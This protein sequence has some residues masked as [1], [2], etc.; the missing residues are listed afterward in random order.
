MRDSPER[1]F[2][3]ELS[4]LEFDRRVLDLAR[5]AGRPILERA[6]FL[7]IF[8]RNLDEF[9]QVRV[10]E[11]QD[12]V[13]ERD[14][15]PAPDGLT[16][17]AQLAAIR[18]RVL[19]LSRAAHETFERELRPALRTAGIDL[20]HWKELSDAERASTL[21]PFDEQ[22][23]PVLIPLGV[24]LTHPFP[25]VSGLS[26][27][28][29]AFV[30]A[31]AG[32]PRRLARVKVPAF[33]P[34]WWEVAPGR[35]TPVEEVIRAHFG[36]L[37]PEDEVAGASF[38]RVTRDAD[39]DLDEER[40]TGDLFKAVEAGLYRRRRASDA[41]RLEVAADLDPRIRDLL[42]LELRLERDEMYEVPG[43]LDLGALFELYERSPSE[44]KDAP[45]T[46]A[47]VFRGG[48]G[49]KGRASDAVF[50]TL[51][52]RDVLVHHPYESFESSVG[53]FLTAA[54]E[55]PAVRV[56]MTTLYRAGGSE[57]SIIQALQG[58]AARGK[59]IVALVELK[60]RFD[61]A[62]NLERARA[63][64]RA[65]AHVVYGVLGL[66]T[67][68]KLAFVV[69]E[70][71]GRLQR[72]CHVATGNYNPVTAALYEDLGLLSSR[73][74]VTRDVAELFQRLTSGSGSR[75]Y[76]ELLVAPEG[77]RAG[78]L[79]RI[80][81]EARPGGR[82][83]MKL[84]GLSDPAIIDALYAASAAGG[85]IDLVVRSI[86]CLRPGIAGLSERIRVRSVLG[87]YL[88]HS[89]IYRFGEPGQGE[90][91]I[92]SADLMQRNLDLRVEA[93]VR[94]ADP[95]LAARI[96]GVLAVFLGPESSV[97]WLAPD[98]TWKRSGSADVQERI[99]ALTPPAGTTIG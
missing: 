28:V 55:D 71:H 65:G 43:L 53:A 78:M 15:T 24:D 46:P 6:K 37:F 9:F 61:E 4:W 67:H 5:D 97:F 96:D 17:A 82:I 27:S 84:N 16:P 92:G 11:L 23:S 48:R 85:E 35:Y 76:E 39:L 98:G 45:W 21:A 54:A 70:E 34:R 44:H 31:R 64:E 7:A 29:G 47:E 12:L 83:I 30:Q 32:G 81:R 14:E 72:Y 75:S 41:V 94:V 49:A 59:Q 8:S 62:H 74:A 58:A 2:N 99:R 56:I 80:A 89:R 13:A 52:E 77:L 87:R 22:I 90:T 69:R 20:A 42:L 60:A 38:F 68:T 36:L 93:L 66:K 33:L 73:E 79:E 1:F 63:L 19:E 91:W 18:E 3:R 51:R 95:A 88:E 50:R 40:G 86:C 57:S 25:F 26:L 10:S